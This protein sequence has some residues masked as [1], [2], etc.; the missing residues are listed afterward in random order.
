VLLLAKR[1][2]TIV[3]LRPGLPAVGRLF[4]L[5]CTFTTNTAITFFQRTVRRENLCDAGSN[6]FYFL[7]FFQ[8]KKM[9]A[10]VELAL[11][12]H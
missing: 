11:Y 10:A 5:E 8:R 6:Y 9:H 1:I 3:L 12:V 2:A 4:K 7:S